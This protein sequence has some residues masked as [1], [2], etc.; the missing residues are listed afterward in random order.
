MG[1]T[2]G[3]RNGAL[4]WIALT[5]ACAHPQPTA[6]R[7]AVV[8]VAIRSVP[9]NATVF[10]N[11]RELGQAPLQLE[12]ADFSEVLQC[13]AKLGNED[14]VEVRLRMLST[15]AGE[16]LFR[17]DDKAKA[18]AQRLGVARLLVFD[19]GSSVTFDVDQAT[20]KPEGVELL[21]QQAAIVAKYFPGVPLFAC[22]HTDATGS[23]EHNL[24]LSLARAEA[25]AAF[26]TE[27]GFAAGRVTTLGF[28]PDFPVESN[29][30]PEGRAR[31]R[32]TELVLPR[33]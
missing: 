20:L 29:D 22:G 12:L 24:K 13:S 6:P 7:A 19:T 33:P 10:R 21:R 27:Q 30:T 23:W 2:R 8:R 15:T 3:M 32:R 28:G 5:L 25:V 18:F 4:L 1:R 16:V 17:F 11:G 31:N 14:P 26:L 9:E